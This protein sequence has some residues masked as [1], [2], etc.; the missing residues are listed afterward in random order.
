[1]K[2]GAENKES[3]TEIL[4]ACLHIKKRENSGDETDK[5]IVKLSRNHQLASF[6]FGVLAVA[7]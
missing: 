6:V 5:V 3:D 1:M 2:E 4:H 7:H